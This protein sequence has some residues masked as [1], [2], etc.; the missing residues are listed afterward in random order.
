MNPD[1][2]N[3][4][5]YMWLQQ[6]GVVFHEPYTMAHPDLATIDLNKL[7]VGIGVLIA[8]GV[9]VEAEPVVEE[10]PESEAA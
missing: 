9:G 5:F 7:K 8:E 4:N 10:P 1:L 2:F 3:D 6:N